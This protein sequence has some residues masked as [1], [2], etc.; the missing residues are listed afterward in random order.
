VKGRNDLV[1]SAAYRPEPTAVAAARKFVRETLQDWLDTR[2]APADTELVDDAVLLTSELVTNA[3]VHAGTQVQVTCKLAAS[4]VEVVVRD[5]HPARMVPG[6]ARDDNIPAERTHGRGLLLP[7][8]LASAWGVSYGA[9]AKAVWFRMGL[10]GQ[11]AGLTEPGADPDAAETAVPTASWNVRTPASPAAASQPAA[12]PSY[13]DLL[14]QAVG[15]ARVI[16]AGDAAYALVADEDGDLSV[17][18]ATGI[19]PAALLRTAPSVATVPFIVDS[20]VLGVLAVA[21]VLP[22]RFGDSDVQR[23]QQLADSVAPALERARLAGLE[24]ARRARID[25]LAEASELLAGPLDADRILA[26]AGQVAVPRLAEWCAVLAAGP[27]AE[28]R[29]VAVRHADESQAGPLCWLLDRARASAPWRR[30]GHTAGQPG[31]EP[32]ARTA[33]R[34]PLAGAAAAG[35]PRGVTDLATRGAWCFPLATPGGVSGL[36]VLGGP[37]SGSPSREVLSLAEDLAGRIALALENAR[38][39]AQQ[40]AAGQALRAVLLPAELPRVPGVEL[41]V[42]H[43]LPGADAAAAAGGDFCDVF[44]AGPGRWRFAVG[45]VC[46]TGPATLAVTSLA[47]STLR[48]LAA[49]G[50]TVPAVLDRLNQLILDERAAGTFLTLVHGE[51]TTSGVGEPVQLSLACAGQPLPLVLRVCGA[52]AEPAAAPQPVLGVID[53]LCFTAQPVRLTAGDL[54]LCVTDGVTR[55]RD[56]DRLLDDDDGLARLLAG[57]AGLTAE[58]VA[59]KVHE[60][61]RGFG[62]HPAADGMAVLAL[63]AES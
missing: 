49:D 25:V 38:L 19:S 13:D 5:S 59:S 26:V 32:Q 29:V 12:E 46:G 27:D 4:A 8:A 9:E 3:V 7:S 52:A 35:G 50:L 22:G 23:L 54:L 37:H 39:A 30:P 28:L 36:L 63:R 45:E 58:V 62:G 16:V 17:R 61:V 57:C 2:P 34:W 60:E 15:S 20:R 43:D 6:P 53:G 44:P 51:I 24:R 41:A 33:R 40:Q 31:G 1:V 14:R 56:G 18:A 48:I 11:Q 42:A 55:R 47:H 21:A 10:A